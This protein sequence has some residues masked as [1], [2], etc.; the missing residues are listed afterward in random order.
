MDRTLGARNFGL[1]VARSIAIVAV[2]FSHFLLDAV[3][4]P[5]LRTALVYM[6]ATGVELFFS[7]S[8]FLIGGLL[9]DMAIDG[10]R[11]RTVAEFWFRRW[12]RTLPLYY[13]VL[14]WSSYTFGHGEP[15]A[16][17][18]LQ[19]FYPKET[20]L[21][22]AGWSLVLEEYFYLFF[23]ATVLLLSSVLGRGIRLVTTTAI[24]LV[25]VCTAGRTANA[26]GY[27]NIG[28]DLVHDNPFMRM[29]CAAYGVLA[30]CLY[31]RYPAAV[32]SVVIR[33]QW[34]IL[35]GAAAVVGVFALLFVGVLHE[36]ERV[37]ALGFMVWG[38]AYFIFQH[39]LLDMVFAAV[40]LTLAVARPRP[41]R[42]RALAW[43]IGQCSLL[44]YS[45]YLVHIPVMTM[46]T[47]HLA[48]P[49]GAPRMAVQVLATIGVSIVTYACIE[50]PFLALRNQVSRR[51]VPVGPAR[52]S[53]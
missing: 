20:K 17:L 43:L 4:T 53:A 34:S 30:A 22:P 8:G 13:A 33:W 39:S 40:V 15:H 25:L 18:F 9:I 41:G 35:A 28:W 1:D 3:S 6:G 44:S 38:K 26:Y 32:A 36:P 31:R 21:I 24:G 46:T 37:V 5:V 11:P 49:S 50:R 29:D 12:M 16:W 23:P 45:I 48:P 19:N 52:L 51:R 14:L 42:D 47:I 10:P 7:L 2:I 27:L